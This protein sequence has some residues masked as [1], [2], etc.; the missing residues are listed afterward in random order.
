MSR[1]RRQGAPTRAAAVACAAS[2]AA[3][4]PLTAAAQTGSSPNNS[5]APPSV[6]VSPPS[7]NGRPDKDYTQKTGCV[8]RDQTQN[9]SIPDRPWGQMYLQIEEAQKLVQANTG[10][11]GKDRKVAVIDTG[12]T[13]HSW[14]NVVG[15]GDYVS[16][17]DGLEDCD[18][19]GTEV[20]GIIAAKTP[21]G[22]G[23]KGVAPDAT[24]VSIR[25]TS[26]NYA[27]QD[28]QSNTK[29]GS[30]Q[31]GDGAGNLGTLAQAVMNA[32]NRGDISVMNISID[33]CRPAGPIN[34]QEQLLQAAI[35]Y[36]VTVKD[37]VVVVAAG[38][39]PAG[40][41]GGNCGQNNQADPNK[42]KFIVTPPWFA[43][44]VLSVAAIQADGSVAPFSVNGPW[45][46]VAAPGTDIISLD[47]SPSATPNLANQVVEG[48]QGG[49]I[50]GT[51]FASPYVAGLA[52]LVRAQFPQLNAR[53]VMKRI[54]ATAQHP[55]AP[56]GRDQYI[57]NG[58][59]D[60]V[61][62]LTAIVPS[63]EGIATPPPERLGSGLP[64]AANKDWAP[65]IVALSGTGGG[66]VVLLVTIF[67][68]HT[69]RRN[70][71]T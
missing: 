15:G 57:G 27:V 20:A 36:A 14:L 28:Q 66:L 52:T 39:I 18:G 43:D 35:H 17:K 29:N 37:I 9:G 30:R 25:Q 60:P 64:P 45:V 61:A 48:G 7:D 65:M 31:Q 49:P 58:V 44:D 5:W 69:I 42:P 24:I 6:T 16:A 59:I 32:A 1:Q 22:I 21:A 8:Q 41:S 3:L 10:G 62:A 40:D 46:S 47:P 23:F 11:M 26:Q 19:H 34:G 33:A 54:E 2:L 53:Q 70:R 4:S 68:M 38:N 51:S 56:G 63:E 50:Q 55:G 67:V 13:R 12:V 71:T